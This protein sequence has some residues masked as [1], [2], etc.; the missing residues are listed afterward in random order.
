M[1]G[2][3]QSWNLGHWLQIPYVFYPA[4]LRWYPAHWGPVALS[5]FTLPPAPPLSPSGGSKASCSML[6]LRNVGSS[7]NQGLGRRI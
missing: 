7:S 1:E 5:H 4:L 6:Q 2:E 3:R